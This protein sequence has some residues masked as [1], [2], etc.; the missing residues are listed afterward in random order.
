MKITKIQPHIVFGG[1]RNWVFVEVQTDEGLTGYGEATLEGKEQAVVGAVEDFSRYL[2]GKDPRQ[3]ELHWAT[4]Y[5]D[6]YWRKGAVLTTALGALEIAM[7]DISAKSLGVP[8][9][10]LFGGP[11]RTEVPAYANG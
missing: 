7:W 4:M 3:V 5:R 11:V 10:R 2:L 1:W 8:I 9:Y 6:S